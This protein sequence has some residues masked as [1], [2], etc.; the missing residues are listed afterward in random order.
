MSLPIT[1]NIKPEILNTS[2]SGQLSPQIIGAIENSIST[3][4]SLIR[5]RWQSEAQNKLMSTRAE[6]LLGLQFDSIVM[7]Y[8]SPLS[9]AVVLKGKLPNMIE[10]GWNQFDMK[11]GF[12]NS[13]RIKKK[14]D[15]G[16]YLTIPY[17]HMTP[18]AYMYGNAMPKDV[19]GVAKKLNPYQSGAGN[20]SLN[21]QSPAGK[22][23]TGYQHKTNYYNGMVRIV[24]SYQ[25]A[26]QSQY[27]TFR[28]VSDK[29]D[30]MS[31]WHPGYHGAHI[32]ESL[33]PFATRTFVDILTNNLNGITGGGHTP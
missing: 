12:S 32:A 28:R 9:G 4:L 27:M 3:S 7:P 29:S 18:G 19:Y 14:K 30:P 23:W 31:W 24:K 15:G 33:T 11:I 22:S 8:D 25:R 16:W 17:R 6:Y 26:T 10:N 21:W 2:L 20:T 5:D 1:I 13:P